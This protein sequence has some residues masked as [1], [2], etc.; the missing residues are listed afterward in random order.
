MWYFV[1]RNLRL[2]YSSPVTVF[3]SLLSSL[4][5]FGVYELFLKKSILEAFL[6]P[7]I[8]TE[9]I[10]G[11]WVCCNM[12]V[13]ASFTTAL[14]GYEQKII[15]IDKKKLKDTII[16]LPNRKR[17][18]LGYIV[19]AY[20]I[21]LL[22]SII[23]GIIGL[24]LIGV[25]VD[26]HLSA[27][28]CIKSLG[29]IVLGCYASTGIVAFITSFIKKTSTMSVVG[30]II[31]VVMGFMIGAYG[32][33]SGLSENTQLIMKC[34]PISHMSVLL[35]KVVLSGQLD[36]V[37]ID[38]DPAARDIMEYELGCSYTVGNHAFT[39]MEHIFVLLAT[40]TIFYLIVVIRN[41]KKSDDL[42]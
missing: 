24:I 35:K 27:L 29:I 25:T 8:N 13:T 36:R 4:I 33:M 10:I 11:C 32:R 28:D 38:L 20:V 22:Q 34:F 37:A 12:I 18:A 15:D 7:N 14:G 41:V 23:I 16:T 39:S 30:N 9:A 31:G 40:G 26:V 17:I 21:S 42:K 5:I 3:F 6:I 2:Y 1:K 19:S